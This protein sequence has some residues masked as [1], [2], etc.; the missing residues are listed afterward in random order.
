MKIFRAA[1]LQ[2]NKCGS[3]IKIISKAIILA[4]TEEEAEFKF[5]NTFGD[6][7]KARIAEGNTY[8]KITETE[9]DVYIY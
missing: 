8:I 1:L 2:S 9:T 7:D 5:R 4:K 3:K 6:Y